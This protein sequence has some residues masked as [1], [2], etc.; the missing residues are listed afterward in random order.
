MNRYL[1]DT[2][3]I[4]NITKPVPSE[5]LLG[6]MAEQVDDNLFVDSRSSFYIVAGRRFFLKHIP[7]VDCF[8]FFWYCEIALRN[9]ICGRSVIFCKPDFCVQPIGC[10]WCRFIPVQQSF[11]VFVAN[12]QPIWQAFFNVIIQR[13]ACEEIVLVCEGILVCE[14]TFVREI[15]LDHEL[16]LMFQVT[17]HLDPC[18]LRRLF[19]LRDT[20]LCALLNFFYCLIPSILGNSK[21]IRLLYFSLRVPAFHSVQVKVRVLL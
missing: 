15:I 5:S 12:C 11:L 1:L 7:I 17:S 19:T 9:D 6:W 14:G 16:L 20:L 10:L 2:N 18:E 4:S 13:Q 21:E 3:I 8:D